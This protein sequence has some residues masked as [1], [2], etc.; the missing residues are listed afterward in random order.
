[1][2]ISELVPEYVIPKI[3]CLYIQGNNSKKK[4]PQQTNKHKQE[5][6]ARKTSTG[7]SK[8]KHHHH[9]NQNYTHPWLVANLKGHSGRVLDVDFSANGKHLATC[10]EDGT[11]LIWP[12]KYFQQSNKVKLLFLVKVRL[13][14][15]PNNHQFI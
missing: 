13:H 3:T 1:M 10:S 14:Y 12:T 2:S 15:K 5:D 7:G 11:V 9:T 8:E 4:N 6:G